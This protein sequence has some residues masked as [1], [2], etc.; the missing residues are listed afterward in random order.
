MTNLQKGV[1]ALVAV[2][3]TGIG[4]VATSAEPALGIIVMGVIA[5][6]GIV[7]WAVDRLY[8]PRDKDEG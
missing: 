3:V 1:T 7:A 8:G 5:S 2:G 4:A 6:V